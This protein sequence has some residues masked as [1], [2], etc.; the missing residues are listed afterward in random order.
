M[1]IYWLT[2]NKLGERGQRGEGETHLLSFATNENTQYQESWI[3][4]NSFAYRALASGYIMR[5]LL[6]KALKNRKSNNHALPPNT[7]KYHL[8]QTEW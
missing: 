5:R 6:T 1:K 7:E 2:A 3:D 4:K 8:M